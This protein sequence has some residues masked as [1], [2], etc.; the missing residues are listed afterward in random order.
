[1]AEDIFNEAD[2]LMDEVINDPKRQR[3]VEREKEERET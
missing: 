1:M 3:E 2:E